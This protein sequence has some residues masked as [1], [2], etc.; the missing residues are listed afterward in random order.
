[1]P[2]RTL[3]IDAHG[4]VTRASRSAADL[5]ATGRR[6]CDVVRASGTDGRPICT[7]SCATAMIRGDGTQ[8]RHAVFRGTPVHLLCASLGDGA[9][10]TLIPEAPAP[11]DPLTPRERQILDLVADG[12]T[13]P[14]IARHLGI[15]GPTVRT[16]VEHAREKLGAR[17]RAEA[18][19]RSRR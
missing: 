7:A 19:A 1:M 12:L 8:D 4:A 5:F 18:V 9:V 11:K 16:H 10:I 6:C 17:T 15:S 2:I 14:E 3:V 13:T